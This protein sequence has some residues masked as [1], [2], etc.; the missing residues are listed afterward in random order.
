MLPDPL[1]PAVVHFPIAL[2]V[3][4]PLFAGLAFVAIRRG[5]LQPRAWLGVVLLQVLLVGFGWLA[6]ETGEDQEKRVEKVVAEEH[7]EAHKERA[8]RFLIA[9]GVTL[10]IVGGGLLGG[11]VGERAR[12][13]AVV[14]TLGV[15][16]GAVLVG[17]S[18][19]D[20]VYR[21]GAANAYIHTVQGG[22]VPAPPG[23]ADGD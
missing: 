18:G 6:L 23:P 4:T 1:H 14:A 22:G 21:Y 11:Q 13:V 20:L 9:A 5:F 16:A 10:V 7:V 2:A 15:L 8:E 17:R 19:G 3:L 12:A